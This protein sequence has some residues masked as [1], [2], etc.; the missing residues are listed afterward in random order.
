MINSFIHSSSQSFPNFK[1]N[2]PKSQYPSI[3]PSPVY[4]HTSSS[5]EKYQQELP[6]YQGPTSSPHVIHSPSPQMAS[7]PIGYGVPQYPQQQI[8]GYSP[9]QQQ[10]PPHQLQQYPNSFPSPY[11]GQANPGVGIEN[12]NETSE[13]TLILCPYCRS[14]CLTQTKRKVSVIPLIICIITFIF[15]DLII[16]ILGLIILIAFQDTVHKCGF[17]KTE[18]ATKKICGC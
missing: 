15:G 5:N 17:C 13:P 2:Q 16:L 10:P 11:P 3:P 9:Y 8:P 12:L 1:M 7:S 14:T 4:S 18:L 6:K